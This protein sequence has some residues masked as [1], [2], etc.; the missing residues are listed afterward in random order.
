MVS[1]STELV[2]KSLKNSINQMTLV[3]NFGKNNWKIMGLDQ[4]SF[5]RKI[6]SKEFWTHIFR[7]TRHVFMTLIFA[8][9]GWNYYPII[10]SDET[11]TQLFLLI[12]AISFLLEFFPL[13]PTFCMSS[14]FPKMFFP[15]PWLIELRESTEEIA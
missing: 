8:F 1:V 12:S 11:T 15:I 4:F 10:F 2:D 5:E 14:R 6:L 9:F 7:P 13:F 3:E